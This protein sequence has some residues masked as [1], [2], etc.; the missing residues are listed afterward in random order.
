[1]FDLL[2]TNAPY[3]NAFIS[4]WGVLPTAFSA[5]A[6]LAV[7]GD[8]SFSHIVLSA[9]GKLLWGARP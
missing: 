7:H 9:N 3:A 2:F 6:R 1:M 5:A 4:H 8:D